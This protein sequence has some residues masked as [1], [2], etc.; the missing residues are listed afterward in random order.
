VA[1]E[2]RGKRESKAWRSTWDGAIFLGS[3]LPSVLWGVA[4]GNL[5]RGLDAS[6]LY[7]VVVTTEDG[8]RL[9]GSASVMVS[10]PAISVLLSALN[11]F[12]LLMGVVTLLL[13]LTHGAIYLSLKTTGD[14]RERAKKTAF[15]LSVLLLLAGAAWALWFQTS[16]GKN[17]TW[18]M[19]AIAAA[20]LIGIVLTTK[21]GKE[22][23]SFILSSVVSIGAVI[24]T[25]GAMYP[26]VIPVHL[27]DATRSHLVDYVVSLNPE[28]LT[29][30]VEA[31]T[32]EAANGTD[33]SAL[34]HTSIAT[35]SSSD[36]TLKLM[37]L[38]A[39][40][41]VPIV[42]AYSIWTYWV[43]RMRIATESI[44]AGSH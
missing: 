27:A 10:D 6:A 21:A 41:F 19:V 3:L 30:G 33:V 8:S 39:V 28:A 12:S 16:Y 20:A 13:F 31:L 24:M 7:D 26:N 1:F 44:P 23:L 34:V 35:A 25:F 2:Y 9:D 5:I 29:P 15:S 17:W 4:F 40:I 36:A 37:T 14:L 43:F 32:T 22:G 42:L 11:P 18:A 38:V